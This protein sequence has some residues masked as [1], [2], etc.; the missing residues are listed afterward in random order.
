[1]TRREGK[2]NKKKKVEREHGE[3]LMK[4]PK[5]MCVRACVCAYV[6]VYLFNINIKIAITDVQSDRT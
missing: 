6:C 1:M 4:K 5:Q 3:I 2:R